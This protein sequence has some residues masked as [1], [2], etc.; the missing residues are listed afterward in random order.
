[1]RALIVAS[2]SGEVEGEPFWKDVGHPHYT[3]RFDLLL[4][5]NL[6]SNFERGLG[7]AAAARR[8]LNL[9]SDPDTAIRWCWCV[10]GASR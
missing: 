10:L 3:E 6:G 5:D 7:N 4:M 9:V 2:Q 8:F 1:M